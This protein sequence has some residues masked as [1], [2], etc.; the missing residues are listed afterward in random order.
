MKHCLE[1]PEKPACTKDTDVMK[2]LKAS[3]EQQKGSRT[4]GND[5]G[6]AM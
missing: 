2:L 6:R 5:R 3:L 1:V 4:M